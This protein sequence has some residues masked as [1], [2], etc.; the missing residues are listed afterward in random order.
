VSEGPFIKTYLDLKATFKNQGQGAPLDF[1]A[2]AVI[3]RANRGI[4]LVVTF[5][6]KN[7]PPNVLGIAERI[8][9]SVKAP[10]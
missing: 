4:L 5:F 2:K 8:I 6:S 10:D 9:A 7:G 3:V 1:L